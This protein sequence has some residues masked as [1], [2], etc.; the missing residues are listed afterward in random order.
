[1]TRL[2]EVRP[3]MGGFSRLLCPEQDDSDGAARQAVTLA[4]ERAREDRPP[5]MTL[6]VFVD[7]DDVIVH[8]DVFNPE[9]VGVLVLSLGSKLAFL[10]PQC[11]AV[12]ERSGEGTIRVSAQTYDQHTYA[13][14]FRGMAEPVPTSEF[15]S[16]LFESFWS[17]VSEEGQ[18]E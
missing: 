14:N 17:G 10:R 8:M 5:K 16:F 15:D 13:V 9:S 1:M 4:L 11:L 3:Q 6:L 2:S 12:V 18:D 7:R